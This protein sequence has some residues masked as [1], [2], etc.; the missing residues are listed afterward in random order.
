MPELGHCHRLWNTKKN[1]KKRGMRSTCT[2]KFADMSSPGQT[3]KPIPVTFRLQPSDRWSHHLQQHHLA[4]PFSQFVPAV[5]LSA[6]GAT[7]GDEL[8]AVVSLGQQR[9]LQHV[10]EGLLATL[11]WMSTPPG[12]SAR[13]LCESP[14]LSRGGRPDARTLRAV[15]TTGVPLA[16]SFLFSFSTPPFFRLSTGTLAVVYV[17]RYVDNGC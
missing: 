9:S 7:S 6:A 14:C 13:R 1:Q 4:S 3:Q 5:Y 12:T 8:A 11:G 15:L 10:S 16:C 2:Q 17:F